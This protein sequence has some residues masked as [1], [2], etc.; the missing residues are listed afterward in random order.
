MD[1]SG[2]R[3]VAVDMDGTL[4]NSDHEVGAGFWELY[5]RLQQAQIVFVAASGRQR[6]SIRAKLA[7]IA[8]QLTVIAENGALGVHEGQQFVETVLPQGAVS[9]VLAAIA[10]SADVHPVLCSA[11][12]AYVS[13]AQ[14]GFHPVMEEYYDSH[15]TVERLDEV[16]AKFLKVALHHDL[17]SEHYIY[18]LVKHLAPALEVK[19]SSQYWVDLSHPDANKGYALRELQALLGIGREATLAIGDYNNDLEML[20]CA[21]Y[22][23]AMANAH[24]NVRRAARY[25]TGSND[26]GGVESVLRAVLASR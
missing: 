24:P 11:D 1:L 22:S 25:T 26:E 4:L 19:V 17:D 15:Q 8:A 7:P 16:E 3:L 18:P 10:G 9:Q 13:A 6:D 12:H 2:I 14:T 23:Y 5:E 21:D 20:A